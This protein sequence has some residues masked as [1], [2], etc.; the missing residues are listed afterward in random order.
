MTCNEDLGADAT[1]FFNTITAYSQP[2]TYRRIE[3]AP[4]GLR[5]QLLR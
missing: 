1:Q 5:A 2:I 3:V 4:L